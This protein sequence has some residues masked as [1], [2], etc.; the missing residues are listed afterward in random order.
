MSSYL[1]LLLA[2]LSDTTLLILIAAAAVS[3]V[4]GFIAHPED[5]W[6]E[7]T[8][9]FIAVFLVS[10]ISAGNDYTKQIQ[11][12]ALEASSAKDERT[13][14]LRDGTIER[15]NPK[16]L[17][18]GD[19]LVLQAGDAIPADSIII[20]KDFVL[21]NESS[22]TG[23]PDDLKKS[24]EKDCFLLSSCLVTEGEECRALVIGIGLHSQWGKIKANLVTE[25]V[26]TPLQDKLEEMTKQVGYLGMIS[27][28]GTFIALVISIW[29]RDNGKDVLDGFINAFIVC[30]TIVVV[31]IPEGL[32]L[33]VTISLAYSPR[34]CTRTSA[35]SA[36][37][38]L[39]R[40]WETPQTSARTR[41]V[42]SL[43]TA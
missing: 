16:D 17:V 43:R 31:A 7:G 9:I 21:A 41:L 15:I 26:N 6:I 35:S 25:A 23:E 11:F 42:L 4:I 27:A 38:L 19:I 20:S 18:V 37:W 32:P 12:K 28:F 34:R 3:L 39:V 30:I 1:E 40:P 29:A 8:A 22:L 2:A 24:P 36:C 14:V 5:G 10:N 13:S 33:A